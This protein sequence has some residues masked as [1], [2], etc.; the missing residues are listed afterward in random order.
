MNKMV[1]NNTIKF[2]ELHKNNC[3]Q[4]ITSKGYRMI[5]DVFFG[6]NK[7]GSCKRGKEHLLIWKEVN[8]NIPKGYAVHHK[9]FNKLNNNIDN[10][11][12][13]SHKEHRKKHN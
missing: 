3:S 4:L 5:G 6:I 12:L 9:D 7:N 10:L 11:E 2:N 8:G 13:L 1:N